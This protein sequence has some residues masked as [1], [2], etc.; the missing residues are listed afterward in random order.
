[1]ECGSLSL[2]VGI[3]TAGRREVLSE[4]LDFIARQTRLPDLL[5]ICP[6]SPDD[7]DAD[8]IARFPGRV[9]IVRGSVGLPSQRNRILSA[10]RSAD[11][12]V[13]FDDDFF[14]DRE[15]LAEVERMFD[16]QPD[17]VASTGFL[18]ADGA[19]GPG[20][21]VQEGKELLSES[22]G[23][24]DRQPFELYGAY[25]CNMS[26]RLTPIRENH[27]LFDEN[28]PLYG[29]QEDIDF[30]RRLASFGKIVKSSRMRGVHL[31]TKRGRTSGVRLGYSQVANPIYLCR[32]GTFAWTRAVRFISRNVVANLVRSFRP[33]PWVDRRGR[34]KGNILAAIDVSIGRLSPRRILELE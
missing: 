4:T 34:L 20:I 11:L 9:E 14:P 26:F 33:E 27:I 1:M 15:Y 10:S 31:G 12:I 6:V 24:T 29:W 16:E 2:V 18:I 28:L 3:A 25:G 13:F 7:V 8:S 5:V 21:S 23:D 22:Q 30:S 17:V 32:K 19:Q